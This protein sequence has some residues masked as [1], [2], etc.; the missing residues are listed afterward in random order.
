[1]IS[2]ADISPCGKYRH[3][4]TRTWGD[5]ISLHKLVYIGLN[6]STARHDVEDNTSRRFMSFARRDAYH[7]YIALNLYDFRST[8]PAG[9]WTATTKPIS[10]V[11]DYFIYRLASGYKDV[12]CAWGVNAKPDR[13]AR[14]V[15]LLRSAKARMLCLGMTKDGHPRHPLYVKGDQPFVEYR[16]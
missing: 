7:G 10:D 4:L 2:G 8:E 5:E 12:C 6:P 13:V 9:L 14:V 3:T 16:P 15:A 1:M 11:N